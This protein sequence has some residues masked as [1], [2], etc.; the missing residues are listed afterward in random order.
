MF[1]RIHYAQCSLSTFHLKRYNFT[2][3]NIFILIFFFSCFPFN[4]LK[5]TYAAIIEFVSWNLLPTNQ[6]C[7]KIE[8]KIISNRNVR[9]SDQKMKRTEL[10]LTTERIIIFVN[11]IWPDYKIEWI[12]LKIDVRWVIE[13]SSKT[14]MQTMH[15]NKLWKTQQRMSKR[16]TSSLKSI[17]TFWIESWLF[18]LCLIA[19]LQNNFNCEQ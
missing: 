4:L 7:Y 3:L 19:S 5:C 1:T 6:R 13:K 16:K 2:K 10:L 17:V 14:G 8:F 15:Q 18:S 9:K 12:T 11:R